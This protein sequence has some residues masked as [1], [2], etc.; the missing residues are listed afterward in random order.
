MMHNQDEL[1][2]MV[3]QANDAGL[4]AVTHCIGDRASDMMINAVEHALKINPRKDHRHGIIHL[5]IT[6]IPMLERIKKLGMIAMV[7]PVFC[8]GDMDIVAPRVG[9]KRESTS[10]PVSYTHLRA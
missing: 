8:G 1:N 10:Y 2:E 5:Q 3:S 7:Q 9:K 4:A 6:D